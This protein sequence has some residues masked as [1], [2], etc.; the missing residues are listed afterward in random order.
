MTAPLSNETNLAISAANRDK[1][2]IDS[3]RNLPWQ[4]VCEEIFPDQT[5]FV[6]LV[7]CDDEKAK[8]I[9][10]QYREKSYPANVLSFPLEDDGGEIF[11]NLEAIKREHADFSLPERQYALYLF[12]HGLLH[13]AGYSH[14]KK[15]A[16]QEKQILN[17][18]IVEDVE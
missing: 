12:I 16:D 11:L 5:Y 13:L 2:S 7:F 10:K 14:G 18:F 8:E 6:S 9:N 3:F 1:D 17:K 15:M 4:E